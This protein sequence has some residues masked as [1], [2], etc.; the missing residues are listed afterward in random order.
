MEAYTSLCGIE[1]ISLV[2]GGGDFGADVF[3]GLTAESYSE[4][5]TA[6]GLDTIQTEFN[7]YL[8]KH[9]NGELDLVDSGCGTLFGENNGKLPDALKNLGIAPDQIG[10]LIMTHL[11]GDH[12]GGAI[13]ENNRVFPNAKVFLAAPE[14]TAFEGSDYPGAALFSLYNHITSVE[15]GT[16]IAPNVW[17][18]CLPGHTAGHMG[19]H[20]GADL[21]L[22]G[23]IAH[24]PILQLA[25]PEIGVCFDTDPDLA[26][27]SRLT[28]LAEIADEDLVWSGSHN[29]S[30]GKFQKL[31][32]DG[33]G[34]KAV[35]L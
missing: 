7:A 12:V 14:R 32:R 17:A 18:W 31:V 4:R 10:R 20:I 26:M 35:S 1:V 34:Y 3:L 33:S 24:A 25:N 19:L 15:D 16:E 23:D 13:L 29:L 27:A 28:A 21:V 5:L 8:L 6:L 2:D 9:P 30:G 11:H 22:A